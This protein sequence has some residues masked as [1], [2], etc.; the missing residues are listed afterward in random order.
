MFLIDT[1]I[2]LE[3]MLNQEKSEE[4]Q[5]F[6]QVVSSN[7]WTISD[8]S[9]HSIGVILHRYKEDE[10]FLEFLHYLYQNQNI[11]PI[12]LD[13]FGLQNAVEIMKNTNL[14]FDDAYQTTICKLFDLQLITFDKDFKNNQIKTLSPSEAIETY[15]NNFQSEI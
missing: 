4:A 15:K 14:D 8:F 12:Q 5:N 10:S 13:Y 1:N 2:F 6:F 7:Y 3:L 9:L 11:T